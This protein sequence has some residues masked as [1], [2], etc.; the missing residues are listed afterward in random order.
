MSKLQINTYACKLRL[1]Q[2]GLVKEVAVVGSMEI[3]KGKNTKGDGESESDEDEEDE[4]LIHRRNAYVRKCVSEVEILRRGQ[5]HMQMTKNPVA[6]EMRR[7]LVR[8]FLKD[9][10]S[11]KKCASCSG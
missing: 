7:N 3:Q 2:Y 8:D 1:L 9:V 6:A 10:A 11:V 5:S 4:D